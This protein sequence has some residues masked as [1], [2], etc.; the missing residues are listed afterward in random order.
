M[1]KIM[2]NKFFYNRFF[3]PP[4]WYT[5]IV[6][7]AYFLPTPTGLPAYLYIIDY[8]RNI[9]LSILPRLLSNFITLVLITITLNPHITSILIVMNLPYFNFIKRF[10]NVPFTGNSHDG[11]RGSGFP[12]YIWVR[13]H[14]TTNQPQA[15][16]GSPIIVV[17]C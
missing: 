7:L 6:A 17:R 11:E 12:S 2:K 8:G 16:F 10:S 1:N 14:L 9:N 4:F 3:L 5:T 15:N 13:S